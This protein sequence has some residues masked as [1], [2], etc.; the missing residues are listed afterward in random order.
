MQ[1]QFPTIRPACILKGWEVSNDRS[2]GI[3]LRR[4]LSL[5]QDGY[6]RG[7]DTAALTENARLLFLARRCLRVLRRTRE[8][9]RRHAQPVMRV[10]TSS[11]GKAACAPSRISRSSLPPL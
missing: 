11:A 4:V 1:L 9:L 6:G 8:V 5:E 7:A 2:T 3:L 10:L